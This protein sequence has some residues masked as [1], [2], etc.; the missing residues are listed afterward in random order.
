MRGRL[1]RI[2]GGTSTLLV[3]LGRKVVGTA[4]PEEDA[5]RWL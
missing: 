2:A 4:Y 5:K 3:H 1:S